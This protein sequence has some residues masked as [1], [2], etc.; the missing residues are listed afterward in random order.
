MDSAV[1]MNDLAVIV[2]LLGILTLKPYVALSIRYKFQL[3]KC[4]FDFIISLFILVYRTMWNLDLCN[5]LLGP[6]SDLF[7]SKYEM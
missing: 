5:S 4:V 7:Q 6:I 3:T 1:A 2:D